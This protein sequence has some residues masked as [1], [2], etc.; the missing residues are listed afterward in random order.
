MNTSA[1]ENADEIN[2]SVLPGMD[3]FDVKDMRPGYGFT[4]TLLIKNSGNVNFHYYMDAKRQSG[5]E[6]LFNQL[7]VNVKT[8]NGN[9]IFSGKLSNFQNIGFRYL[10]KSE[11]DKLIF[12]ILLPEETGNDFQGLHAKIIYFF[13]AKQS[14]NT[15]SIGFLPKT[16]E[17]NPWLYYI[18][19]ILITL[20][21]ISN[22][23][24]KNNILRRE[25]K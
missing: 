24:L 15:D 3:L 21:G 18:S 16:G 4:K 1:E 25:H 23:I 2:I 10:V 12:Q 13:K 17:T 6:K 7:L 20:I 11:D 9:L 5:S 14:L 8:Q 22:L 19:G